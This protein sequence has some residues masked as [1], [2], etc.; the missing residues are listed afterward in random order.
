[1]GN[2][3]IEYRRSDD[4]VQKAADWV[5]KWVF[6]DA[7]LASDQAAWQRDGAA[8][9]WCSLGGC[10]EY[11]KDFL[12]IANDGARPIYLA[13]FRAAAG[14]K[15]RRVTVKIKV[16]KGGAI[17]EQC[18][19]LDD[20]GMRPVRKALD[21]IPLKPKRSRSKQGVKLGDVY[22]KLVS[23]VNDEG[24][25]LVSGRKVA[26]IFSPT[27]TVSLLH[28]YAV[29]WGQYWD[30]DEIVRAKQMAKNRWYRRLVQS[31]GQLWRPLRL[32]RVAFYGLANPLTLSVTF[33]ARNLFAAR[34]L[35]SLVAEQR[36]AMSKPPGLVQRGGL[37]TANQPI[38]AT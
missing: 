33:W 2:P 17:H 27:C 1:M 28:H 34:A 7:F 31:A 18:I 4:F 38:P 14:S 13:M 11:S 20:L 9:Q 19:T 12:A 5:T 23:A 32:R 37:Q 36:T 8:H 30:I 15:L 3:M 35:R 10:I 22:L 24:V 21:G 25:D 29:R 16:K 6:L 26:T